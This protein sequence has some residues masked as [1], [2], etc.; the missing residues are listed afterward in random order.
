MW[1][2]TRFWGSRAGIVFGRQTPK[3]GWFF[4]SIADFGI[5]Y[6]VCEVPKG[7]EGP[8]VPEVDKVMESKRPD[9]SIR[10]EAVRADAVRPYG[11]SL[12]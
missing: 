7:P 8:K 6:E 4:H 1:D 12:T 11:V 10:A 5:V 3:K 2:V 9:G